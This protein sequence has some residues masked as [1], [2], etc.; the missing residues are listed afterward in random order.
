MLVFAALVPQTA[1]LV[2]GVSGRTEVLTA[3]RTATLRAVQ[4]LLASR[5]DRVVVVVPGP[6]LRVTGLLRPSLAAAGLDDDRLGWAPAVLGVPEGSDVPTTVD[7]VAAA[8]GLHLL[9]RA[10]WTGRTGVLGVPVGPG[11]VERG[12]AA[13]AGV[14]RVALL[15]C[16]SLSARRGPGSPL[17][18]DERAP[19]FD[20]A[21]LAD[22]LALGA[23]PAAARKARR[24]LAAVPAELAV[25]LAV[26]AWA[27]W[28]VLLG[29]LG[30]TP[31]RSEEVLVSVPLGAT[32]AVLTWKPS[33]DVR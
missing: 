9:A 21:V 17:A 18:E 19:A 24:G 3:E 1:L 6:D 5:P 22:L 2:P 30:P 28:Q 13:V 32:Y 26:S 33:E 15:L 23:S 7:D 12:R 31:V 8:V 29:A 4:A 16:A 10:G 14:D 25:A 11:L 20:E 27:P